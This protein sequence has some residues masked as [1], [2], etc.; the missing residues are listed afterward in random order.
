MIEKLTSIGAH[1]LSVEK[2]MC[3]DEQKTILIMI[4]IGIITAVLMLLAWLVA[5]LISQHSAFETTVRYRGSAIAGAIMLLGLVAICAVKDNALQTET[6]R[7]L[8]EIIVE[9]SDTLDALSGEFEIVDYS[10]YPVI[11]IAAPMPPCGL[12]S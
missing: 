2:E 5:K 4:G 8:Y 12:V 11:T 6:G 10:S 1:V 9:D 3:I 7:A